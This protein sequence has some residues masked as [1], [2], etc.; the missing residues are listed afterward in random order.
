VRG[1]GAQYPA[2]AVDLL[3][4]LSD[5]INRN[6]HFTSPPLW[7]SA[8]DLANTLRSVIA[9]VASRKLL[10]DMKKDA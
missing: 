1:N 6:S 9:R 8:D 3:K 4:W 10:D 2:L 5:S 7:P